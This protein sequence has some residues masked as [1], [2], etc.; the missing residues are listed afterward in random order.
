LDKSCHSV[1]SL[2]YHLVLVTK[3]RKKVF[4]EEISERLKDIVFNISQNFQVSVLNQEVNQDH[5]HIL[6]KSKPTLDIPK[7]INSLKGVSSRY[8]R[9]EFEEIKKKLW[10]KSFWSPS[11]CLISSGQVSLDVLIKYIENQGEKKN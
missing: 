3:Y 5:V 7:Y 11:Y 9:K 10:G 8:L 6:F 4:N 1:Y 2:N